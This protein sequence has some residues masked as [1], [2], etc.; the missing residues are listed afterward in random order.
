MSEN[1]T[2]AK[3]QLVAY[4]LQVFYAF[5]LL[6][7]SRDETQ[8]S[9]EVFD[10]VAKESFDEIELSQLKSTTSS[11]NPISDSSPDFWKTIYNWCQLSIDNST[12][13][14]VVISSHNLKSG[15]LVSLFH[16]AVNEAA[17]DD[18][19]NKAISVLKTINS[20]SESFL[21][22]KKFLLKSENSEKFKNVIS[23]FS[24]KTFIDD[25]H[26]KMN[27]AFSSVCLYDKHYED[28]KKFL[29]GWIYEQILDAF[30]KE[31]E[32]I[33]SV[34]DF[35]KLINTEIKKYGNSLVVD[36]NNHSNEDITSETLR[37]PNYIKQLELIEE[38][39]SIKNEAILNFIIERNH[40][41]KWIDDLD[42]DK[43]DYDRYKDTIIGTFTSVQSLENLN[44]Q[45]DITKGKKI[46][47]TL[48]IVACGSAKLNG[49][50]VD[51]RIVYGTI[52]NL[53]DN[54]TIGWHPNY[55]DEIKKHDK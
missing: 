3:S 7:T 43:E 9:V 40:I 6:C 19:Y 2:S 11:S 20:S 48:K 26:E 39:E 50:S 27:S 36:P 54:L 18:A 31:K 28:I 15:S 32:I 33:F 10:D 22:H 49:K 45:D 8:I 46:Y 23:H 53:S 44:P 12:F 17:I 1:K 51:Q 21:R 5:Y 42:L 24:Y 16:D 41:H 38:N 13:L 52:E 34:T 14:Y 25:F 4:S 37:H 47:H 29:L 30:S 35:K 55:K